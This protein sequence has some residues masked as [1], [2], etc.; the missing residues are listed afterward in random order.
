MIKNIAFAILVSS[1]GAIAIW[2]TYRVR[3]LSTKINLLMAEKITNFYQ[4]DEE[5]DKEGF[6][7]FVSD[8]RDLAFEY[9]EEVQSGI[10]KFVSDVDPVISYFDTYGEVIWTPMTESM[11]TISIAYKDLKQLLPKED[12]AIQKP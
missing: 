5:L 8:S 9:I 11:Q 12:D 2:N 1:L 6:L 3:I 4:K 7:K 10:T